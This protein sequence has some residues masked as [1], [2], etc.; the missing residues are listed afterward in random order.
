MVRLPYLVPKNRKWKAR[1]GKNMQDRSVSLIQNSKPRPPVIPPAAGVRFISDWPMAGRYPRQAF[2]C[3]LPCCPSEPWAWLSFRTRLPDPRW[4]ARASRCS[5][6]CSL[7]LRL[8]TTNNPE[9]ALRLQWY[10][11]TM[12]T[13]FSGAPA[14][15]IGMSASGSVWNGGKNADSAISARPSSAPGCTIPRL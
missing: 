8:L 11:V 4:R 15:A 6:A 2:C 12:P 5:G 10:A 1:T 9:Y 13:R 14:T 3:G 7:L